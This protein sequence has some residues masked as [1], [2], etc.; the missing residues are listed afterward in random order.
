VLLARAGA[1]NQAHPKAADEAPRIALKLDNADVST[2]HLEFLSR[3]RGFEDDPLVIHASDV[4]MK[5][6]TIIEVY[7]FRR[8]DNRRQGQEQQGQE[9]VQHL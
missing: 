3:E 1:V 6:A 7:G 9:T 4:T 2:L 8:H 5:G